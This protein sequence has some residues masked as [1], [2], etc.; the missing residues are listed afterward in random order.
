MAS[1][2]RERVLVAALEMFVNR[3]FEGSPTSKIAKNAGVATGTLF[4]YFSTKEELINAL[5]LDVKRKMLEKMRTG[6]AEAETLREKVETIW[7]N[8]IRWGL[9]FPQGN[10]FFAMFS[11]SAYITEETREEGLKQFNFVLEIFTEGAKQG[12]FKE[13]PMEILFEVTNGI[14]QGTITFFMK[15]PECFED[16]EKRDKSFALLWDCLKR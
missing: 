2:K 10:K 5:Y 7:Y 15:Y 9:D 16:K 4:H 8:T 1:D 6:L 12:F 11:S 14:L 3:G 13:L